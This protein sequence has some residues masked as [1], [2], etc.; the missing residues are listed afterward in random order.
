VGLDG[1]ELLPELSGIVVER[2]IAH[3][4]VGPPLGVVSAGALGYDLLMSKTGQHPDGSVSF[5]GPR[6]TVTV[7]RLGAGCLLMTIRG[8][9]TVDCYDAVIAMFDTEVQNSGKLTFLVDGAAFDSYDQVFRTRWAEWLLKHRKTKQVAAH[10]LVTSS[11]VALG[12]TKP[13][14]RRRSGAPPLARHG[15]HPTCA[16]AVAASS[17]P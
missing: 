5:D 15:L 3:G 10:I 14:L 12:V 16:A 8:H 4:R 11:V 17:A 1:R 7:Q 6:G 9:M 13:K 2:H